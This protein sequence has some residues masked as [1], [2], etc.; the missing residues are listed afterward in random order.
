MKI[1][2][3]SITSLFI[4]CSNKEIKQAEL[5]PEC[6]YALDSI[7]CMYTEPSGGKIAEFKALKNSLDSV[8]SVLKER[9]FCTLTPQQK[10]D[11][12]NKLLFEEQGIRFTPGSTE[13]GA[14]L[15]QY[16]WQT[17]EGSCL[18][19]SLLY[20]MLAERTGCISLHGVMLPGH[21][22]VRHDDGSYV[23]NIEPN[24]E[25]YSH[26]DSYYVERYG[27]ADNSFY[28]LRNCGRKEIEAVL[29]YNAGLVMYRKGNAS[30]A[31]EFFRKA[32][33][34]VPEYPDAMGNLALTLAEGK[35][36]DSALVVLSNYVRLYPGDK[37]G[38]INLGLLYKRAEMRDSALR[39]FN[40][41][42]L[43]FPD[44]SIIISECK[45][46]IF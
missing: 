17:R 15:P 24:R 6:K 29:A 33:S 14:S 31:E 16:G 27:V 39:V 32:L 8:A 35:K 2:F 11:G 5:L 10:V 42:A 46:L 22:F 41:A 25:G 13:G 38:H 44:D 21:F 37:K 45:R 18:S 34:L 40:S 9:G 20:L 1:L 4:C 3:L 12:L 30:E 36:N 28:K 23:R 43:I 26:P 19:V 7:V